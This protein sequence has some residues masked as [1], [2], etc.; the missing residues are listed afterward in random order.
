[1]NCNKKPGLRWQVDFFFWSEMV[2]VHSARLHLSHP[3]HDFKLTSQD[4]GMQQHHGLWSCDD[5]NPKILHS[6]SGFLYTTLVALLSRQFE[7]GSQIKMSPLTALSMAL[8]YTVLAGSH[9]QSIN[10]YFENAQSLPQTNNDF[11]CLGKLLIGLYGVFRHIKAFL[12]PF[13]SLSRLL[14]GWASSGQA[15][16]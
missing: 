13:I 14:P 7:T 12:G 4:P 1:M 9:A 8:S 2:K 5:V 3:A 10:N 15:F 11:A 16:N 6:S